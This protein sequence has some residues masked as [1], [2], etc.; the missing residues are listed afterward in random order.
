MKSG[1]EDDTKIVH[2]LRVPYERWLHWSLSNPK[3]VIK[4]SLIALGL[5]LIGFVFLGKS[6]IPVIQEGSI[7][8][9]IVRALNISL[10]ESI[11]LEFE[12]IKRI[13]TVPG[14]EIG[15]GESPAGPWSAK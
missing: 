11:K 8:P 12:A 4:R 10:D 6:F 15:K 2:K 14:V 1:S 5:S 9:V 13:M 3:I 7:T